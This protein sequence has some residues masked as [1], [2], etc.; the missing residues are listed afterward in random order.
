MRSLFLSI[1]WTS[2]VLLF[3]DKISNVDAGIVGKLVMYDIVFSCSAFLCVQSVCI[4]SH[5][6]K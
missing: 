6:I 2:A 4:V 1:V 5:R 3:N